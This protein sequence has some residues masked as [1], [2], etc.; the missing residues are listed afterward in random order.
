MTSGMC[1]YGA[2]TAAKMQHRGHLQEQTDPC[3]HQGLDNSVPGVEKALNPVL[4][5]CTVIY[6]PHKNG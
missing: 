6:F 2:F 5:L 1:V 4:S 3:Q